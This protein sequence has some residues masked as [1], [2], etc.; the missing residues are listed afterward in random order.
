METCPSL[1]KLQAR[2][3]Q[4][5]DLL[6]DQ[7]F[8][9]F[10]QLHKTYFPSKDICARRLKMLERSGYIE[11]QTLKEAVNGSMAKSYFPYLLATPINP[12]IKLYKLSKEYRKIHSETNR[13]LKLDLVLHQTMLTDVRLFLDERLKGVRFCLSDP[14]I[15]RL[16]PLVSGRPYEMTPDISVEHKDFTMAV[17]L[18]RTTKSLNRYL[19][20][21]SFFRDSIYHPV[22]YVYVNES[23]LPSILKYAGV[24]RKFGFA[25][26]TRLDQV[27]TTAWGYL[28]F[29][30][31]VKKT[32]EIK[33]K[34]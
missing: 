32:V 16:S 10:E 11:Q 25:H 8:A 34:K 19:E 26:Y 6:R 2:D 30:E 5:L 1:I 14:Q 3:R 33:S 9:T 13:L 18:E 21:F 28:T 15:K 4:I 24:H 20:R 22:L 29:E 31:W 12:R 27:L 7:G 23:T 17:E